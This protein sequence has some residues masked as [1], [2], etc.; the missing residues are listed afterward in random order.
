MVAA[1]ISNPSTQEAFSAREPVFV[2]WGKGKGIAMSIHFDVNVVFKSG[3]DKAGPGRSPESIRTEGSSLCRRDSG[4]III[5][6]AM[7]LVRHVTG[8]Q[9]EDTANGSRM[10]WRDANVKPMT[11]PRLPFRYFLAILVEHRIED[12]DGTS[13]DIGV[14]QVRVGIKF[15]AGE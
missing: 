10:A 6:Y 3:I 13:P 4:K 2:K 8:S 1:L 12:I 15:G 7:I 14:L 9:V 5:I 11:G